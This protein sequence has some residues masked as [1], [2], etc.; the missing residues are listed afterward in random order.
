MGSLLNFGGWKVCVYIYI[1]I[2]FIYMY[3]YIHIYIF[4]A[5]MVQCLFPCLTDGVHPSKRV[6][7]IPFLGQEGG[8][9]CA[10]LHLR[11]PEGWSQ[12]A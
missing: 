8:G 10:A 2:R 9:L 7:S 4:D 1:Y 12:E 3:T 11:H 6:G 5:S